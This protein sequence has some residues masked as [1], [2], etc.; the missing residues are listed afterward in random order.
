[1]VYLLLNIC[2]KMYTDNDLTMTWQCH[3]PYSY[4]N[5]DKSGFLSR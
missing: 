1:M 4:C 5:L 3:Q 2:T